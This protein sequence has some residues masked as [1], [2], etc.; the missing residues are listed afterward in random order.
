MN[1]LA[2]FPRVS[3]G[4]PFQEKFAGARWEVNEEHL[5]A[6]KQGKTGIP[7]V[8]AAMRQMN[9]MGNLC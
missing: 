3:M 4:Q 8:D 7:I 5:A 2:N 9:E 1:V 6:W